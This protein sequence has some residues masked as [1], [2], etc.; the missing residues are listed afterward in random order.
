MK[1]FAT[2]LI[3]TLVLTGLLLPAA[4][5]PAAAAPAP[6]GTPGL[7]VLFGAYTSEHLDASVQELVEMNNWLT[8]N[9]ASGVTF[10]GNFMSITFNP[11]ANV[12]R[13]MDAAW[14]NGFVP[15]VNL[16]SSD[17]G[18]GAYYD[19]N[20][21]YAASIGAG[22]CDAKIALWAQ[23][24]KDWAGNDKFAFIAP[25]PEMNLEYSWYFSNGP[26]FILAYRRIQQVFENTG[27]P[28]SAVQWVFAPN[29]WH[30]PA[31]PW[32][33]FENYYP[34]DEHV[35]IVSFSAYNYGGCPAWTPWRTWDTFE[36][37]IEP[38][39]ARMH[40]MA[41]GKPIF[42]AQTGTVNVPNNPANPN[43][44]KSDWVYD[45]FSKLA[46]YPGVRAIMYFNKAKA[47]GLPNCNP[48]DYRIHY[49][50]SNGE[51]GFL[52]IMKD[53][54]YGKWGPAH[55]NWDSI[56]F[57][58]VQYVFSDVMPS[59]PFSGVPNVWYY[60]Q[61]ISL[62][63]AGITGGFPDGTYQPHSPVTRAQIAIFLLKT[64][65]GKD[66]T[67]P[68]VPPSFEDVEGHWAANWIEALKAAGL[69]GGFPDGTYRPENAITRAQMAVFVLKALN[70]ADYTPP[71]V[72]TTFNDTEGHWAANWI[73]ALKAAGITGGYPDGTYRPDNPV[74]R[75]EMA[76]FLVKAF[77]LP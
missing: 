76:V 33:T 47:E 64:I 57:A 9:G 61:V 55:N 21:K 11:A 32:T 36:I 66:Y 60:N 62:Y 3:L 29:G 1:R 70:G 77:G 68:E 17:H 42:I 20:C 52:E 24:F 75:A 23:A 63:N 15:F 31:Y 8:G 39:L 28:E 10:A 46:D 49:G 30:N 51:A 72:E 5:P 7:P 13:E 48:I 58:E 4:P 43:E 45:T 12:A 25:L 34:G 27:V 56:A 2:I 54:R 74:S 50:G 26:D 65:E 44:N 14:D 73:E 69:T 53:S 22:K 35:D 19:S 41:P 67:P 59:H 18:E 16:Q 37:A 6:A 40:N 71:S 38:Y